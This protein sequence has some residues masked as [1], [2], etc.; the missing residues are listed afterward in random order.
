MYVRMSEWDLECIFLAQSAIGRAK[1]TGENCG[2]NEKD[3]KKRWW[4]SYEN[5]RDKNPSRK[6]QF[7]RISIVQFGGQFDHMVAKKNEANT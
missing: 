2:G 1:I 3:E 6:S 4:K 5:T 7:I